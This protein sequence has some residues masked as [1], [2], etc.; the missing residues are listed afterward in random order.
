MAQT[1]GRQSQKE[2]VQCGA[3]ALKKGKKKVGWWVERAHL[4][5][6]GRTGGFFK[7]KLILITREIADILTNSNQFQSFNSV[8]STCRKQ[9][10][11]KVCLFF[12]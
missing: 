4:M 10:G 5:P 6:G 11:E 9:F 7:W 1:D 12:W 2:A 8:Q 3:A